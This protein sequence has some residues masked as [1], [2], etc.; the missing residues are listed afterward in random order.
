MG[1]LELLPYLVIG[2]GSLFIVIPIG[3]LAIRRLNETW[4]DADW[5]AARRARPLGSVESIILTK[6]D[7]LVSSCLWALLIESGFTMTGAGLGA[8]VYLP[9]PLDG[10]LFLSMMVY[11]VGGAFSGLFVNCVVL[12]ARGSE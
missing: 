11:G 9:G 3:L 12:I 2:V 10:W 4:F 6:S 1:A 7:P 8:F 5:R